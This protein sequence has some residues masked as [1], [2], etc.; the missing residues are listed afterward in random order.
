LLVPCGTGNPYWLRSAGIT[1]HGPTPI[2]FSTIGVTVSDA[3]ISPE[4]AEAHDDSLLAQSRRAGHAKNVFHADVFLI[5]VLR[6]EVYT[7]SWVSAA[8]VTG[9]SHRE[10][11]IRPRSYHLQRLPGS[12]RE[13]R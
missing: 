6:E 1:T 10:A 2:D 7:Y 8:L 9:V 11:M 12:R 3:A 5:D 13:G 4:P